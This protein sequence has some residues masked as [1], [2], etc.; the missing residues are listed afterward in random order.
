[1]RWEWTVPAWVERVIDGDTVVVTLDLGWRVYRVGERLRVA[2]INA[3]ER[4]TEWR[5]ARDYAAQLLP[6]GTRVL[7]RSQA[8]PSFERTVGWIEL[9]DGRDFGAAM[10]LAG[11]AQ[12][13][14]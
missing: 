5:L 8:K 14:K 10:V 12:L 7:V 1:M 2:G 6:A 3:P 9:P 13:V 4:G 11:H